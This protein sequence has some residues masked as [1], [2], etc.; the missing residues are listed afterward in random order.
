MTVGDWLKSVL[1]VAVLCSAN[2]ASAQTPTVLTVQ[3]VNGTANGSPVEGDEVVVELYR[4]EGLADSLT[5]QAGADGNAVFDSIPTEL[6]AQ[7]V[8]RVKHQNMMFRGG[9][10]VLP[11]DGGNI[12]T[13]VQVYDVSDD[14][15]L[16]SVGTHHVN[17]AVRNGSLTFAE[18]MQLWNRS[19]VAVCGARRDDQGKPMVLEMGLPEGFR[20]LT[21]TAY[22][23]PTALVLTD[24]GFYDTLATPPG[25][26]HVRFSYNLD[27]K[28]G[29]TEIA[30]EIDLP[31]SELTVF[32]EG[33]PGK[34]EGLGEPDGKLVDS[35][36]R[37]VE[38]YLRPNLKAGDVVTLQVSG[39]RAGQS[40]D[41]TWLI[42]AVVFA[43]VMIVAVLKVRKPAS[44]TS[45]A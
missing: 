12:T 44:A 29:T 9:P 24:T 15:G 4:R 38:Y 39:L 8:A 41:Y 3:V 45:D 31:T 23:V 40:Q 5:A 26:H 6:P 13:T 21:A 27:V 35:Q 16:L 25:E 22:L 19:D 18:Y 33:P 7:A 32:W 30:R 10:V 1:A 28:R 34:I 20:D 17:I 37:P 42:L 36:G 11:A 43:A 2:G 14:T